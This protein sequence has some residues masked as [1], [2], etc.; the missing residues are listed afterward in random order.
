MDPDATLQELLTAIDDGDCDRVQ[1]LA[2]AL[3][4]WIANGGYPPKTIGPWNL[5]YIWHIAIAKAVLTL[6]PAHVRVVANQKKG[7]SEVS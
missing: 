4:G 7:E 2:E 1:E 6:A 3:T 5:G